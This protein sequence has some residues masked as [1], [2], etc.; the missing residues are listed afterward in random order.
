VRTGK[1]ADGNEGTNHA[2]AASS[3]TSQ[4]DKVFD[5]ASITHNSQGDKY[6]L[7][8]LRHFYAVVC[9]ENLI[10]MDEVTEPLKLAVFGF[11]GGQC[12]HIYELGVASTISSRLRLRRLKDIGREQVAHFGHGLYMAAPCP[13]GSRT[14]GMSK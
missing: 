1:G 14:Q 10:G 4:F 9:T 12:S 7:Y 2:N 6:T 11:S 8:S 13:S 5:L 3:S